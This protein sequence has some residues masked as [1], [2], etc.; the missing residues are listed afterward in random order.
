MAQCNLGWCYETGFGVPQD[1]KE[2]IRFWEISAK[3]GNAMA[4]FNLGVCYDFGKGVKRDIVKAVKY[5]E[6]AASQKFV[7]A[8]QIGILKEME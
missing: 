2:A 7:A 8:R 5:Y 1:M 4:Q 3:N 6:V